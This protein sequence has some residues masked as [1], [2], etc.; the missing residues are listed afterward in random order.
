MHT[1]RAGLTLTLLVAASAARGT[2][3]ELELLGE[4]ALSGA[5]EGVRYTGVLVLGP[6]ARA[7]FTRRFADGREEQREGQARIEGVQLVLREGGDVR[8]YAL[9]TGP[10]EQRW[11]WHAGAD[12]ETLLRRVE[13]ENVRDFLGRLARDGRPLR[14]LLQK[15][16]GTLE[17]GSER[18]IQRS[19]QPSPRDIDAFR[20]AGGKTVLSLNGDQDEDVQDLRPE[21]LLRLQDPRGE[22]VNLHEYIEA[23]GLEHVS[24]GMSAQRAPSDEELLAVFRVLLDDA[25]RP[26]LVHCQGGSDRTGVICALYAHEFL[27]VSKAEAKATMRRHLWAAVGGTEIQGAYLDLYPTGRLRALLAEAG[28]EVPARYR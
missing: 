10:S 15:N 19:R 21:R 8:A 3:R 5:R 6:D 1:R 16:R 24:V 26:V 18:W 11:S 17:R 20:R 23:Q 27:G 4:H 9:D 14:W 7:R 13:R 12:H 22:P 25:R 28:V 2:A